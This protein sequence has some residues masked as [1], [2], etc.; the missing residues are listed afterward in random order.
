M[1]SISKAPVYQSKEGLGEQGGNGACNTNG[2]EH[3]TDLP[4]DQKST[5][6]ASFHLGETIFDRREREQALM[7]A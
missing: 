6:E 3:G 2:R 4:G 1:R 5:G 7:L